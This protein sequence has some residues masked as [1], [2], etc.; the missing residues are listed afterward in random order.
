MCKKYAFLCHE[1]YVHYKLYINKEL[2]I[3]QKYCTKNIK[4]YNF[5]EI[6]L[7]DI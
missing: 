3:M 2:K 7:E 5:L 1:E 4:C 6:T